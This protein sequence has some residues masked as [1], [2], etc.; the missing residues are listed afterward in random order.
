MGE[1]IG[2]FNSRRGRIL[3]MEPIGGGLGV[4]KAQAPLAEVFR[5]SI[6]LRSM[7]QGR[8]NFSMSFDHYE[9]V[10]QRIAENII[11]TSKK[12]KLEEE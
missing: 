7:T 3:G 6:D 11:A 5:Y 12:D 1:I 8:G 9:E 10:P 4:V 2:D